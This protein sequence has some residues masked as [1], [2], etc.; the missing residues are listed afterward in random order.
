MSWHDGHTSHIMEHLLT[1]EL[2]MKLRSSPPRKRATQKV[3]N[4]PDEKHPCSRGKTTKAA[5]ERDHRSSTTH[6]SLLRVHDPRRALCG[7]I[8]TH[9]PPKTRRAGY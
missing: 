2:Q 3:E 4:H 6:T 8:V 7:Q 1:V 5:V 9:A